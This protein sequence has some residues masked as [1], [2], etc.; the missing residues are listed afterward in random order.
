M[1]MIPSQPERGGRNCGN[2]ACFYQL[3]HPQNPAVKQGF[4]ALK[5]PIAGEVRVQVPR[6]DK[7]GKPIMTPRGPAMDA[8]EDI[9]FAHAPTAASL[10]CIEGW[11]PI[12]SRPGERAAEYRARQTLK[13]LEP[14]LKDPAISP[15]TARVALE[16]AVAAFLADEPSAANE[17]PTDTAP[18]SKL[19]S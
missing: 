17:A 18:P 14:L 6:L 5:P 9:A 3:P 1:P 8:V 16:Q 13:L 10:C 2:C 4:C 15:D 7:E 11:R 12:G 19:D